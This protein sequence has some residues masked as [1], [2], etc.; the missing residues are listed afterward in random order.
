VLQQYFTGVRREARRR[1]LAL[2]LKLMV[3]D[4]A[5]RNGY[6][7]IETSNDSLNAP[8]WTLN[9]GLG[10]RKVRETIQFACKLEGSAEDRTPTGS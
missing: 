8:M 4:F 2:A 7:R 1:K 3:I 9:K 10:F 6:A 5:K